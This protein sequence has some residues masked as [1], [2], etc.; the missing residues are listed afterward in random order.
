VVFEIFCTRHFAIYTGIHVQDHTVAIKDGYMMKKIELTVAY[1]TRAF[2]LPGLVPVT[3]ASDSTALSSTA[4]QQKYDIPNDSLHRW[5]TELSA[6]KKLTEFIDGYGSKE[7]IKLL[8]GHEPYHM[9]TP[10]KRGLRDTF[11]ESQVTILGTDP[12]INVSLISLPPIYQMAILVMQSAM[13]Q[14]FENIRSSSSISISNNFG[15]GSGSNNGSNSGSSSTQSNTATATAPA[16]PPTH[17]LY[18]PANT[19]LSNSALKLLDTNVNYWVE[20]ITDLATPLIVL[21]TLCVKESNL[22]CRYTTKLDTDLIHMLVNNSTSRRNVY[23][24]CDTI[25]TTRGYNVS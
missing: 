24:T 22:I 6:D 1:P 21:S 8:L 23:G 5:L 17:A 19:G 3:S 18:S 15:G 10:L 2:L 14:G 20:N 9:I 25:G 16:V 4:D 12:A 11:K 13:W 7:G